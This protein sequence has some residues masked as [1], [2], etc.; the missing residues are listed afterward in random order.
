MK[1]MK[2]RFGAPVAPCSYII[3]AQPT[4]P[5][6][7][8]DPDTAGIIDSDRAS[9]RDVLCGVSD[10]NLST[11]SSPS[12]S[13]RGRRRRRITICSASPISRRTRARMMWAR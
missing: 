3:S 7:K 10:A 5:Q 2:K 6:D 1:T 13:V 12:A 9:A 11:R 4:Q 8:E